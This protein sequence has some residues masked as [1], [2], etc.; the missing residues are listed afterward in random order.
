MLSPVCCSAHSECII[1]QEDVRAHACKVVINIGQ[2]T[3]SA[4]LRAYTHTHTQYYVLVHGDPWPGAVA[5]VLNGP[6]HCRIP[7]EWLRWKGKKRNFHY[8][9]RIG[10][11]RLHMGVPSIGLMRLEQI[12]HTCSVINVI[13]TIL[14]RRDRIRN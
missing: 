9:S 10:R 5:A 4:H 2:L 12:A 6:S 3:I 14:L 1:Y 11:G 8:T 7:E 13:G